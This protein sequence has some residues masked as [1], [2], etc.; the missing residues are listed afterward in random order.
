MPR[1]ERADR[2]EGPERLPPAWDLL[3]TAARI[4]R[5]VERTRVDL[6]F[7]AAVAALWRVHH[8]ELY[9][10][11]ESNTPT[12]RRLIAQR[13]GTVVLHERLAPGDDRPVASVTGAEEALRRGAPSMTPDGQHE[14][15]LVF[16]ILNAQQQIARLLSVTA[17]HGLARA[18]PS[19]QALLDLYQNHLNLIDDSE[20][21]ALTGLRNRRTFDQ[22]LANLLAGEPALEP[23]P[24]G[25]RRVARSSE[26]TESWLTVLDIDNFK[27]IN[28]RYGHLF[29]DEVLILVANLMQTC[30]RAGDP[31]FRF[32]GEEFVI[33]LCG[34][35][36]TGAGIAVDRFRRR[37]EHQVFPQV[38]QITISG[39]YTEI[40]EGQLASEVLNR[41]DTALYYAKQHGRNR[42]CCYEELV[43]RGRIS[44]LKRSPGFGIE[45]F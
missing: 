18:E 12:C 9:Q 3:G 36:R 45:L 35:G 19:L 24:T 21:D 15:T 30:F 1:T 44:P 13:D 23:S 33:V 25:F 20:R 22:L 14:L 43:E 37:L 4:T 42:T 16:P 10:L 31:L 2:E 8:V 38:G 27:S 39:G 40:D 6:E 11:T 29:G 28:D 34:V 5:H 26:R 32:G 41:A 7:V 17:G